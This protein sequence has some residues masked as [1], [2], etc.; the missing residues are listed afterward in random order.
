MS[1]H[2]KQK[3][4]EFVATKPV[5]QKIFNRILHT[6]EEDKCRKEYISLEK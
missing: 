2:D 6:E 4:K 5:L 3:L 1:F